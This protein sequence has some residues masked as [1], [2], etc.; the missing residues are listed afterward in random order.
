MLV[1]SPCHWM[2]T[3]YWGW[4]WMNQKWL[5]YRTFLIKL[6]NS[7]G[8]GSFVAEKIL[9]VKGKW[10]REPLSRLWCVLPKAHAAAPPSPSLRVVLVAQSDST[11]PTDCSPLGSS[12]HGI[13]QERI[14]EWVA[15]SSS[16][17]SSQPR[18]GT[19]INFCVYCI[20]GRFF[21]IEPL[22]KPKKR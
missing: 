16:R 13:F 9:R 22:G 12:V 2:Q 8:Q 1:A 5:C 3:E 18:D 21:T 19:R 14:L 11:D 20:A 4:E 10:A 7:E 15:I 6:I 17:G